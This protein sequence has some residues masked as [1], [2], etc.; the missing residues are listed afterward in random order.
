MPRSRPPSSISSTSACVFKISRT[1]VKGAQKAKFAQK[2]LNDAALE[3]DR[4]PVLNVDEE[5]LAYGAGVS[6]SLR[7]MRNLSKNAQLDFAYRKAGIMGNQ[8]LRV[9]VR[10]ILRRGGSVAG[11]TDGHPHSGDALLQSNEL[12]RPDHAPG[13]DRGD[14]QEDDA[15]VPGRVLSSRR[16][17][18]QTSRSEGGHSMA[19]PEAS[20]MSPRFSESSFQLG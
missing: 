19:D 12:R 15:Q 1:E 3:I 17:G 9:R 6:A 2:M 16:A 13:K 18:S 20:R 14:P 5:L 4:L 7:G 8:G 11:A 10:R